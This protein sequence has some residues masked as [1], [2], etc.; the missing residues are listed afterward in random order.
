[1][2]GPRFEEPRRPKYDFC[3]AAFFDPQRAQPAPLRLIALPN[4]SEIEAPAEVVP[5]TVVLVIAPRLPFPVRSPPDRSMARKSCLMPQC[6]QEPIRLRPP[7]PWPAPSLALFARMRPLPAV[8]V[9]NQGR[10]MIRVYQP[11][12]NRH[13]E[14]TASLAR[15][16]WV[17]SWPALIAMGLGFDSRL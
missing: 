13:A 2:P 7:R 14:S 12:K 6:W 15:F 5:V 17:T 9:G 11:Q 4:V 8:A 16:S 10:N 1:M 3:L